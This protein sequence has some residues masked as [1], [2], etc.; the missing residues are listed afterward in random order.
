M[1]D[2]EDTLL[3]AAAS[4]ATVATPAHQITLSKNRM[5]RRRQHLLPLYMSN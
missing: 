5:R 4:T 2:D 3:A 1:S